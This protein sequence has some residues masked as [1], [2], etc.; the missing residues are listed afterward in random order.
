MAESKLAK[1]LDIGIEMYKKF[2]CFVSPAFDFPPQ[3]AH[4][5]D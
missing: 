4:N 3:S 2:Y 1:T 5:K